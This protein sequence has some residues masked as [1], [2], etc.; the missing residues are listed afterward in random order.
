MTRQEP[1]KPAIVAMIFV[2]VVSVYSTVVLP[3]IVSAAA[4]G[5]HLAP[6]VAGYVASA[7]MSGVAI[8]TFLSVFLVAGT[9]R[10]RLVDIG[11]VIAI[12]ANLASM[13]SIGFT[14]LLTLRVGS[15][16]GSG[17]L[18]AA[19]AAAVGDTR[20]PERIFGIFVAAAF[21]A[22]AGS[23]GFLSS[24][25][26]RDGVTPLFAILAALNAGA[27]V[28]ARWF[29]RFAAVSD[30]PDDALSAPKAG[31]LPIAAGL[32]GIL[33]FYLGV[34]STWPM[35]A[36]LG[37]AF[38]IDGATVSRVLASTSI[39]ALVGATTAS[40]VATRFGRTLPLVL[41]L[42][43]TVASL[44]ILTTMKGSGFA[45]APM[46]FLLSWNFSVP[47]MM[48][49]LAAFDPS[50]RAVAFNMTLQYIGFAV[51]PLVAAAVASR[52]GL[53]SVLI[54]GI[55]GCAASLIAFLIALRTARRTH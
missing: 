10:R 6:S 3:L 15:G 46:L 8:G 12:A 40:F 28:A 13:L 34:G 19:M 26:A 38:R 11:A 39:A 27:L 50:G 22:A 44:A 20:S 14:T 25:T 17:L 53:A 49:T 31:T 52:A 42:G 55:V 33:C 45:L 32:A 51:G 16:F 43:L 47:Y 29:P 24:L 5:L 23:F 18:L 1:G 2:G 41:G 7:E 36:S 30:G 35:M 48:G 37:E 9:D 21:L 4:S 54:V